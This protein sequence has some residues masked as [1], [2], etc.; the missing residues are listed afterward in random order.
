M[1][2][3]PSENSIE[4]W[5]KRRFEVEEQRRFWNSWNTR[6]RGQNRK[7]PEV[8]GR[9][10]RMVIEWIMSIGQRDLDIL[11]VGCGSGWLCQ[12]LVPFGRVTGTDLSDKVLARS[13]ADLPQVAF[14]AGDFLELDFP[15][16]GFDVVVS[17]EV[18]AHVADQNG[19]VEKIARL[20]RPEGFLA[21]AT[22]N[23]FA[24]KRWSDVSPQGVGQIR[25]WVDVKTLRRLLSNHFEIVELTSIVPVGDR[26]I[27]RWVNAPKVNRILS[28]FLSQSRI[29][30]L[31][32]HLFLGHTL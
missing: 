15:P 21:L 5:E 25:K 12:Q 1:A 16:C 14:V 26:G 32:E 10:A 20:L 8:N 24:L 22:Q 3:D 31:K 27:L 19:F 29:E 18:L 2:Q 13:Q 17:L 7:I 30:A 11:E 9:Q 23:R 6:Y 28:I 4:I